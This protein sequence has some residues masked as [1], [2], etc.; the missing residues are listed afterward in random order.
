MVKGTKRLSFLLKDEKKL[1]QCDCKLKEDSEKIEKNAFLCALG[2]KSVFSS[3][4]DESILKKDV[5]NIDVINEFNKLLNDPSGVLDFKGVLKLLKN[6]SLET[7]KL[8]DD[9][10]DSFLDLFEFENVHISPIRDTYV[11][12]LFLKHPSFEGTD[13]FVKVRK[14]LSSLNNNTIM[15]KHSSIRQIINLDNNVSVITK[16]KK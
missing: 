5:S 11:M 12:G 13:E 9:V 16:V 10:M 15:L 14:E 1:V 6:D 7:T 4:H 8:M 3:I 2:L